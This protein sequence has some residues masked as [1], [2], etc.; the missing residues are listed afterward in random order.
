M[1][2]RGQALIQLNHVEEGVA[3]LLAKCHHAAKLRNGSTNTQLFAVLA[4]AV[5]S[6]VRTWRPPVERVFENV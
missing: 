6:Q 1:S 2:Y 4:A 3:E 5:R